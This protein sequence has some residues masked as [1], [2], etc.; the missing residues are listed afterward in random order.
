VRR[1]RAGDAWQARVAGQADTD[2][3]DAGAREPV[4][5]GMPVLGRRT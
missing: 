1:T 2:A 3:A 5:L 4:L